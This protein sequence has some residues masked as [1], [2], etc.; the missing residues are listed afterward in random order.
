ML[1]HLIVLLPLAA[2]AT[3]KAV[4]Y[5]ETR[6]A[7]ILFKPSPSPTSINDSVDDDVSIGH[8][9]LLEESGLTNAS[10][11]IE[12]TL[13]QNV[14]PREEFDIAKRIGI[15]DSDRDLEVPGPISEEILPS[16]DLG[17]VEKRQGRHRGVM[18]IDCYLAPDIC[19]NAG[20]YQNC[21]RKA[22]G[23][24]K[25]VLYTNGNRDHAT[26]KW[27]RVQSGVTLSVATPCNGWPF[28]QKFWHPQNDGLETPKLQTDEWPMATFENS[29]FDPNSPEV[30][31]FLRCMPHYENGAGSH[32]WTHFRNC[33]GPYDPDPESQNFAT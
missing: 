17:G 1:P 21:E 3:L 31:V 29:A 22:Y 25:K 2:A 20:W 11:H 28:A 32:A 13:I 26:A 9:Y 33:N 7:Q 6:S 8:T 18:Q 27:S 19:K 10:K 4:S 16:H 15:E 30:Q 24:I 14:H 5:G 23:D 12:A